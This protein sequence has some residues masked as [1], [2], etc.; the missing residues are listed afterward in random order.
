M[1]EEPR[2]TYCLHRQ[3]SINRKLFS[4]RNRFL[5]FF[6]LEDF[7]TM[8]SIYIDSLFLSFIVW[9]SFQMFLNR[10]NLLLRHSNKAL[11]WSKTGFATEGFTRAGRCKLGFKYP[12]LRQ[13]VH[14][15][16][17]FSVHSSLLL[18]KSRLLECCGSFTSTRDVISLHI[19]SVVLAITVCWFLLA[20]RH[21][22]P[23]DKILT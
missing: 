18:P 16:I 4:T 20:R 9:V 14:V 5:Q 6:L 21:A 19:S 13:C 3:T 8:Q 22:S 1:Q 7:S 10:A 12:H 17:H 23:M 15:A 11:N 2:G